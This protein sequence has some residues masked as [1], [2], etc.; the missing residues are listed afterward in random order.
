MNNR[1][2]KNSIDYDDDFGGDFYGI[3]DIVI[4]IVTETTEDIKNWL[5]KD[6]KSI[7]S[8]KK[9]NIHDNDKE[10]RGPL[11]CIAEIVKGMQEDIK[12]AIGL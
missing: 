1:I 12:K 5:K 4:K 7:T 11:G 2:S 10:C 6:I 8:K 9:P 3:E